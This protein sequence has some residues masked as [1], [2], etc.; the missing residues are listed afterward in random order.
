MIERTGL[1]D[2]RGLL[3]KQEKAKYAARWL[4]D[5]GALAQFRVAVE[6]EEE[7]MEGWEALAGL[8]VVST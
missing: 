8:H 1:S 3:D 6:V 2:I 5:T 4:L 7:N